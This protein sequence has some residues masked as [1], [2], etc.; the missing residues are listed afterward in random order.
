[1][2]IDDITKLSELARIDLDTEEKTALLEDFKSIL[3]Y[4]DQIQSVET[5][6]IDIKY[7]DENT[8]REDTVVS[9]DAETIKIIKES[10]PDQEDG[11]LK[12]NTVLRNDD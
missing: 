3:A 12:V 7:D 11:F 8:F 4:V 2:N 1:M 10:F 5:G 9:S 6:D